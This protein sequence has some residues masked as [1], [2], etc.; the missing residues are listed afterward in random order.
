[1][2]LAAMSSSRTDT[3]TQL[4]R[5]FVRHEGVFFFF[6]LSNHKGASRNLMGISLK[7]QKCFMQVSEKEVS[8]AF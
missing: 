8:R 4:V 7:Y 2:F 1:M 6:S 3:V 5:S